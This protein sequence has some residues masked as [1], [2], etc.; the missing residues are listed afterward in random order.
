MPPTTAVDKRVLTDSL[1]RVA[2]TLEERNMPRPE[3][4]R[5][6]KEIAQ[7]C[8]CDMAYAGSPYVL[9]APRRRRLLR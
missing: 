1:L 5:R 4:L 2:A 6:V 3:I 8:G 7:K 9:P